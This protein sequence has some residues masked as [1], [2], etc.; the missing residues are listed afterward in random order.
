MNE[1]TN[2]VHYDLTNVHIAPM[3][4]TGENP[5]WGTPTRIYGAI[6]MDLAAQGETTKLRAD[7]MDY[8]VCKANNGYEGDLN[9][10]MVTDWIRIN[11]LGDKLSETD[12]VLIENALSEGKPFAMMFE[13]LG[14]QKNRRHVLYNCVAGRPNIKGENKDNPKAPDTE[15][16]SLTA[17]PLA[18]GKVKASTTEATPEETY[19]AWNTKVWV[20]DGTMTAAAASEPAAGEQTGG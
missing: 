2:K 11:I 4:K 19:N 20:G 15:T 16:L 1:E 7:G 10:A 18:D 13:F 5:E 8:Y 12:K 6:S 17:S 14:D 9:L 3:T